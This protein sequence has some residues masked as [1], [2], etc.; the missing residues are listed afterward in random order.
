[1][2]LNKKHPDV[3]EGPW[4]LGAMVGMTVFK[5]DTQKSKDFTFKLFDNGV[6]SFHC[7]SKA[8][9]SKVSHPCRGY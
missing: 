2:N 9:K 8:N 4:G 5:G 6:L 3:I 7:W 1:M